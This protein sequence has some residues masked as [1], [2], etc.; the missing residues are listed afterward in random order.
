MHTI[1][2]GSWFAIGDDCPFRATASGGDEAYLIFG[3]PPHQHELTLTREALR[4][5]VTTG[6]AVLA[7]LD[8]AAGQVTPRRV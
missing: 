2:G 5:L 8:G 3:S 1:S 4:V 6:A 7:Q